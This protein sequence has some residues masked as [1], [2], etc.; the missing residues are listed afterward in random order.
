MISSM[1]GYGRGEASASRV[2]AAVEVR[3]VNSRFLE[4]SSRL[5]RTMALRENDVKE[6][7]RTKFARGKV[8]I[9]VTISQENES[10]VPLKV[11]RAAARSYYKLLKELGKAV[12]L[13]EKVT[14][15]HLLHF[16][17][18][19]ETDHL[20]DQ[21]ERHWTIAREAVMKALDE[22]AEMRRREGGELMKDL[23]K[24]IGHIERMLDEIERMAVSRMPEEKVKLQDR[25]KE[26]LGDSR[27]IDNDRLELEIAMLAD[28]L[29]LTEECVRFRS[30]N[31]FFLEGMAN[32]EAVGRKLNFLIQEMNRE[33]NTIGSKAANADIAQLVV[34][35]KE[36][37]E[38]IR[39]QLQ[40][41]E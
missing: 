26:L 16:P 5:P 36:E 4:V 33:A 35:V 25:L 38:K 27:V 17:E 32:E 18:V 15:D 20:E 29:D 6:L 12:K 14:L 7:V 28:K 2:I 8:N 24:R 40:N 1:T 9:V 41:V 30:H 21:D 39:E 10:E 3:S 22:T 37:L 19:I 34:V 13:K 23:A 31:K 11:N